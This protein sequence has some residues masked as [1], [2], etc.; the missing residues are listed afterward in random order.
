ME[1]GPRGRGLIFC[2]FCR[3]SPWRNIGYLLLPLPP[4]PSSPFPFPTPPGPPWTPLPLL[5][6]P[7]PPCLTTAAPRMHRSAL[8]ASS[9]SAGGLRDVG[10]AQVTE[11]PPTHKTKDPPPAP[12]LP[13]PRPAPLCF[14]RIRLTPGSEADL[15]RLYWCLSSV[16]PLPPIRIAPPPPLTPP[17]HHQHHH[18][19]G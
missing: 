2:R 12:P 4:L 10:G 13:L 11:H 8:A 17:L 19:R 14:S 7:P 1:G 9:Q 18:L 3:N 6:P 16:L 5:Q 15:L